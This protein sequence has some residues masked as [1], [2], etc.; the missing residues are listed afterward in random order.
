MVSRRRRYALKWRK[1]GMTLRM[2]VVLVAAFL[3]G[4]LLYLQRPGEEAVVAGSALLVFLLVALLS[5]VLLVLAFL[6][7]RNVVKLVL[8]RRRGILGSR[9]KARLVAAFVGLTLVPTATTYFFASGLLT[10]AMDGWFSSQIENSVNGAV[11]IARLHVSTLLQNM[12][13][14]GR[15]LT[16]ELG[17]LG[18]STTAA[19]RLEKVRREYGLFGVS[20]VTGAHS[21]VADAHSAAATIE[22]FREPPLNDEAIQ[23]AQRG[24]FEVLLEEREA[25]SFVRGYL[26]FRAGKPEE[27][28][29]LSQRVPPE[30]TQLLQQVT[31]SYR[32][33][34]QLKLYRDPLKTG[35]RM[36]LAMITGLLLFSA[37]WL[38]FYIAR[39]L[40]GP[41]QRLAR[42][43]EEVAKG[44][45]DVHIRGASDD[46]LGQLVTSFNRMTSDLSA[47]R[48]ESEQHRAYLETILGRLAVGVVALD[49]K[50][51]ITSC[52]AAARRILNIAAH[53]TVEHQE[54]KEVFRPEDYYQIRTLLDSVTADEAN[55]QDRDLAISSDGR[56]LKIVCTAGPIMKS[57][58]ELQGYVLIFD[59]VTELSRAQHLSAWREVARRIAHEIKNP[60]TPI[61]LSAQ[62]LQKL[63]QSSEF[64]NVVDD[65]TDVIVTHVD[66]I[67][68]LVN[69][70]SSFARMP[71]VEFELGDLNGLI[72]ETVAPMAE[73]HRR[74]MFQQIADNQLPHIMMDREQIRR[75]LINLLD[76]ARE[77]IAAQPEGAPSGR[78]VVTTSYLPDTRSV[79]IEVADNGPG[80]SASSKSSVFEPYFTTKAEGT[81][82][83]LAIVASIVAE[84]SGAIEVRANKPSGAVFSITLPVGQELRTRH[85]LA[86]T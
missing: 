22:G 23:R 9:L 77:A 7:G 50:R 33:Y 42:G 65:C 72:A 78:I 12:R 27:V 19:A 29:V 57:S 83:G 45:L 3:L 40:S 39:E 64:R 47:S 25:S 61:Q 68:R 26:A 41:I 31:D 62:R 82:L 55:V 4:F 71:A 35:Y 16:A 37:I 15:R 70:F 28:I 20:V 52:N 24:T 5:T 8:D 79:V 53:R 49:V 6:I 36:M 32:E 14:T 17:P 73:T 81:G 66:S 46:E 18:D 60:L 2:T 76:N 54:L 43:T 59:D 11:E 75:M 21:V 1:A 74:V 69:E 56:E 63:L 30:V 51:T 10:R 84:H 85:R 38:A 80:I 86:P 44:N 13:V 58:G 34:E 48:R 67:K